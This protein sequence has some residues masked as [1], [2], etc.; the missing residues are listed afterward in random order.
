MNNI[1]R[2]ITS[3][4]CPELSP[5][6][7]ECIHKNINR[8]EDICHFLGCH[9]T[10]GKLN[11]EKAWVRRET[12]YMLQT[13]I[14]TIQK[15]LANTNNYELK[16]RCKHIL[17][18][19]IHE[20]HIDLILGIGKIQAFRQLSTSCFKRIEKKIFR[21]QEEKVIPILKSRNRIN[22]NFSKHRYALQ[23][24]QQSDAIEL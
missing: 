12:D 17:N 6:C 18:T 2:L 19:T 24:E 13:I 16:A 4:T 14:S 9:V 20:D 3:K 21:I 8:K 7:Q 10:I 1:T 15:R 5:N 11:I 23:N 22:A